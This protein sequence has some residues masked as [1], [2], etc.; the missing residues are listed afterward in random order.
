[1][2]AQQDD[3]GMLLDAVDTLQQVRDLLEALAMGGEGMVSAGRK[4]R[5]AVVYLAHLA[6]NRLDKAERK[7]ER[8]RLKPLQAAS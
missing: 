6:L 7:I 4:Q 2:S 5:S 3:A 8:V 1:M